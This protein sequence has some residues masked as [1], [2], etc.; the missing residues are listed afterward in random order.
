[1]VEEKTWSSKF[2]VTF[3]AGGN[4]SGSSTGGLTQ[5]VD[6]PIAIK[7]R[8]INFFMGIF[9]ILNYFVTNKLKKNVN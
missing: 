2:A 1:V 4:G 3:P 8:N 5:E 7:N 6:K 9:L